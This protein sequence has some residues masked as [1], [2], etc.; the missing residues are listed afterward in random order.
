MLKLLVLAL[1]I[2]ARALPLY[3]EHISPP[4]PLPSAND[5]VPPRPMVSE[6]PLVV[7]PAPWVIEDSTAAIKVPT[8]IGDPSAIDVPPATGVTD[9]RIP[10]ATGVTDSRIPPA[11]RVIEDSL[12]AIKVPTAI[13]DLT[14]PPAPRVIEDSSAAIKVP[15][16]IGDP[17]AT[18]VTDS[19]SP[20]STKVPPAPRFIKVPLDLHVNINDLFGTD[21]SHLDIKMDDNTDKSEFALSCEKPLNSLEVGFKN[22]T[23]IGKIHINEL[24]LYNNSRVFISDRSSFNQVDI[25]KNSHLYVEDCEV[26]DSPVTVHGNLDIDGSVIFKN[27]TIIFTPGSKLKNDGTLVLDNS[28]IIIDKNTTILLTN[29][30]NS[31]NSSSI[32]VYGTLQ[33]VGT[34]NITSPLTFSSDSTLFISPDSVLTARDVT[35]D[36]IIQ[37]PEKGTLVIND[38]LLM[39]ESSSTVGSWGRKLL[40][41]TPAGSCNFQNSI[42]S[43]GLL[44]CNVMLN[45]NSKLMPSDGV[46]DVSSLTMD[47]SSTTLLNQY[48]YIVATDNI[49]IDGELTIDFTGL[50]RAL[51][52]TIIQSQNGIISGVFSSFTFHDL[53]SAF[54]PNIVYTPSSI[55]V[56]TVEASPQIF[57]SA[58]PALP[59]KGHVS[60]IIITCSIGG[61]A[62][63]IV[64]SWYAHKK[65]KQSKNL[66]IY[67]QQQ[68]QLYTNPLNNIV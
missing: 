35:S 5:D 22:I 45:D 3:T 55:I 36:G 21:T 64:G 31:R 54:T 26:S 50:T 41:S 42:L 29:S 57:Y 10:P 6:L 59:S 34:I 68:Q 13:G 27:S 15:T 63:L 43:A 52:F 60:P 2:S 58:T 9:S 44:D 14:R 30:I 61:V 24:V 20:V 12:T 38:G 51:N 67:K 37:V 8:A 46:L 17:S 11:P 4:P 65:M 39:M 16:D 28:Y 56:Q 19:R 7:P 40:Q 25:S 66:Y 33:I 53:P 32:Q 23:L 49:N 1:T 47:P 62:C 18:S 48:S